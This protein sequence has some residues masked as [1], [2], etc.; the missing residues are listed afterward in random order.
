MRFL[1]ISRYSTEKVLAVDETCGYGHITFREEADV[2]IRRGLDVCEGTW[3]G[4]WSVGDNGESGC[5]TEG[6]P[7]IWCVHRIAVGSWL[8]LA[9]FPGLSLFDLLHDDH[10]DVE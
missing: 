9:N 2:I 5:P 4:S 6:R 1:H 3:V 8:E 10:V 7:P